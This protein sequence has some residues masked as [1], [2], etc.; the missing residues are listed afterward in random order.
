MST[1]QNERFLLTLSATFGLAL[2]AQATLLYWDGGTSDIGAN[3]DGA[4]AGGAGIWNTTLMNWDQGALSHINWNSATPDSAIFGGTPSRIT[5]G[6][7]ITAGS[8]TFAA[9][10]YTLDDNTNTLVA[11]TLVGAGNLTKTGAGTFALSG[12]SPYTGVLTVRDG[13]VDLA[14]GAS[15]SSGAGITLQGGAGTVGGTSYPFKGVTRGGTLFL[16]DDSGMPGGS[17]LG[18]QSLTLNNGSLLWFSG[19]G[20]DAVT[21]DTVAL[22]GGFNSLAVAPNSNPD[23]LKIGNLTRSGD[24]AVEFRAAYH[25]L[26][27]GEVQIRPASIDGSTIANVNGILGGWAFVAAE[28]WGAEYGGQAKNFARWDPGATIGSEVGS[29][30]AALPDKATANWGATVVSAALSTGTAT[31]NWLANGDSG[32][33][34]IAA[35]VTINSLIEQADVFINSGATLTLGSGGYILRDNNFW[36]QSNGTGG[37]L[38]SGTSNLYVQ[39]DGGNVASSDQ[40]IRVIIKDG[41][42]GPVTLR[43]S[44]SGLVKLVQMNTYTGGT[45]IN[46]GTLDLQTGGQSGCIR[47]TVTVNSGGSLQ[48]S[49]ADATG[50]GGGDA[51]LT[52][53][54]LNGGNLNINTTDNQTLGSAVINMTGGSI[55]GVANGNLDFYGGGSALNTFASDTTATISGVPLAPMRQGSTSFTVAAGTTPS[56]IDLDISSVVRTSP[57]GDNGALTKR[58]PGTMRLSNVNTYAG[59]NEVLDGTLSVGAMS[60]IGTGYLAV[61]FGATFQYT[62]AGSETDGRFIWVDTGPATFDVA[63]ATGFLT[64]NP[65][66]GTI[67][68][69]GGGLITK[70]GAGTLNLGGSIV[71]GGSTAVTVNGGTLALNGV[72]TYAGATT[73]NKGA[74]LVNGSHSGGGGYTVASG[75]TLGGTGTVVSAVSVDGGARLAPGAAANEG[76]AL[77]VNSLTLDTAAALFLDDPADTVT[78]NGNLALGTDTPVTVANLEEFSKDTPHPILT[79]TGTLSGTFKPIID[80]TYWRIK[81]WGNTFYLSYNRGTLISVL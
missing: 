39:A 28:T 12:A 38:T 13:M 41:A 56:G 19:V 32:N 25:Q 27:T 65:T 31:E 30:V 1:R 33:W 40:A 78:V 43:K 4:S 79:Y 5:L 14:S 66:G 60:G 69:G 76:G 44:G 62:G 50:W 68:G 63:S 59:G 51:A 22:T 20:S 37:Y 46:Q 80:N 35:D 77:T 26:G 52:T 55:T 61:K 42:A 70:T 48:A 74:L 47:G 8:L 29:I 57:S 45:V 3:G 11:S 6:S 16:R 72:N 2:G 75:A 7:S 53:I 36:L 17:P 23:V 81:R 64:L 49:A 67:G 9:A 58:G 54:N 71:G 18:T 34:S 21:L 10:G 24:A 73:V 15:L